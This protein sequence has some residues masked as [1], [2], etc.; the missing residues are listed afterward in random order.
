MT[1]KD[2]AAIRQILGDVIATHTA[3]IDGKFD[4]IK[5]E[6]AHIKEQTTKTNGRVNKHDDLILELQKAD[7]SHINNCPI[8]QRVSTLE[9]SEYFK[10]GM[11]KMVL[12]ISGVASCVT[13]LILGFLQF[14]L[15]HTT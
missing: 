1:E 6:L 11:W 5:N 10:K 2:H 4:V 8:E 12:I 7:I 13:G 15:K 3:Q 14:F 9:K